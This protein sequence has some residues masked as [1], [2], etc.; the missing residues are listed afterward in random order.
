[1][2]W[3]KSP[4]NWNRRQF[5]GGLRHLCICTDEVPALL[6]GRFVKWVA[7]RGRRSVS[8][9]QGRVCFL[10]RVIEVLGP[11]LRVLCLQRN[12]GTMRVS[13]RILGRNWCPGNL[14]EVLT[15]APAVK[16]HAGPHAWPGRPISLAVAGELMVGSLHSSLVA[17]NPKPVHSCPRRPRA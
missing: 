17:R 1:M 4:E 3:K 5:S 14:S 8:L 13:L 16:P 11:K 9:E 7:L 10:P 6:S 2:T 15:A 12:P